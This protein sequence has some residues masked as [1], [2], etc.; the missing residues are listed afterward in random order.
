MSQKSEKKFKKLEERSKV[1][2]KWS[3]ESDEKLKKLEEEERASINW[4]ELAKWIAEGEPYDEHEEIL[5]F[6]NQNEPANLR[7]NENR[8]N[9]INREKKQTH[10]EI[11]YENSGKGN[12]EAEKECHSNISITRDI[13]TGNKVYQHRTF[14]IINS[15]DSNDSED[16]INTIQSWINIIRD[17]NPTNEDLLEFT[18]PFILLSK[19]DLLSI[20]NNRLE[21]P[22]CVKTLINLDK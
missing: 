4:T 2:I 22:S 3:K 11:F 7:S 10:G 12:Q 6:L 19:W 5:M 15:E 16:N 13:T 18:V 21:A 17:E 9:N 20:S 14:N 1:S 8:R